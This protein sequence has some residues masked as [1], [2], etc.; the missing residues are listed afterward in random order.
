MDGIEAPAVNVKGFTHPVPQHAVGALKELLANIVA[1][2]VQLGQRDV[3]LPRN[4]A[5]V[6]GMRVV[7]AVGRV[8]VVIA[9]KA[10]RT[11]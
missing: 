11:F 4:V 2:H 8:G 1:P 10:I 7:I 9:A 5:T 3:V 6:F